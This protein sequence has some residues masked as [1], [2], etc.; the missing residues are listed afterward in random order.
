GTYA[1]NADA[2]KISSLAMLA[3]TR[4]NKPKISFL[5]YVVDVAASND[6]SM[7]EFRS[8]V[9]DFQRMSKT[10]FAALEEEMNSLVEG[11]ND[12]SKRIKS[13]KLSSQFGDFFYNAKQQVDCLVK[14]MKRIREVKSQLAVHFCEEP[15]AFQLNDCYQLFADFFSRVNKAFQ[16]NDQMK[17]SEEKAA[18]LKAV[19][20]TNNEVVKSK[21]RRIFES[22]V[23]Q[24]INEAKNGAY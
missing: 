14:K 7:L 23:E 22:Q 12:I 19:K 4:A 5:H 16:E 24:L 6:A 9:A 3:D 18:K 15:A 1:G 17:K 10:P 8:K 21:K 13:S 20:S 2:I 11:A